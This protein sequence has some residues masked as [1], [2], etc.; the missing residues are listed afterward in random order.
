[1]A[2]APHL[3]SVLKPPLLC[4]CVTMAVFT[5][6]AFFFG[7]GCLPLPDGLAACGSG[8]GGLLALEDR[9]G[10]AR[11]AFSMEDFAGLRRTK[12]DSPRKWLSVVSSGGYS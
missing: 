1:M 9:S 8:S 11:V 3:S 10:C 12:E 4:G 2:S 6:F 7:D 5:T